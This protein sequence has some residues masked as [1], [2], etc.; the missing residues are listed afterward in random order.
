[1]NGLNHLVLEPDNMAQFADNLVQLPTSESIYLLT[2][3]SNMAQSRCEEE[4]Q[5]VEVIVLEV[6]EVR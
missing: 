6:F 1:M 4:R 3:F 5:F 2:T